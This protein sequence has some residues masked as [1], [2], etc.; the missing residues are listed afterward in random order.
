MACAAVNETYEAISL[1]TAAGTRAI[2]LLQS[3]CNLSS[4]GHRDHQEQPGSRGIETQI[5]DFMCACAA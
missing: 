2:V 5:H 4:M 3:G 1:V